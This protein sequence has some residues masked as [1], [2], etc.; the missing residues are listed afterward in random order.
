[1]MQFPDKGIKITYAKP[2][3]DRIFCGSLQLQHLS[4]ISNR[5]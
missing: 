5:E 1:M 3:R 4:K 2:E